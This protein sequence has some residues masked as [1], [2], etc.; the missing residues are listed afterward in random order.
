MNVSIKKIS[1]ILFGL[2]IITGCGEKNEG[3][4]S[5]AAV[6]ERMDD[7]ISSNA[8]LA[9]ETHYEELTDAVH[10]STPGSRNEDQLISQVDAFMA[11]NY[12]AGLDSNFQKMPMNEWTC[13]VTR[14]I[15][16]FFETTSLDNDDHAVMSLN[17]SNTY[18]H[19]IADYELQFLPEMASKI[20]TNLYPN[21]VLSFTGNGFF[22]NYQQGRKNE[23]T[24]EFE[25]KTGRDLYAGYKAT[26]DVTSVRLVK[27]SI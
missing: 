19:F 21:D 9:F 3:K 18:K 14:K 22:T 11:P 16:S 12:R 24:E 1:I 25:R 6:A 17:C 5:L 23:F 15:N 8:Q 4:D 20:P 27:K 13:I 10:N 2:L 26:V 7:V